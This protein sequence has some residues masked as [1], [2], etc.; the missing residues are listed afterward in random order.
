[1]ELGKHEERVIWFDRIL[2]GEGELCLWYESFWASHTLA[3]PGNWNGD[4][5]I[6]FTTWCCIS[7]MLRVPLSHL[8]RSQ[9][10]F[11]SLA[12][13]F[14]AAASPSFLWRTDWWWWDLESGGKVAQFAF[15][16]GGLLWLLSQ[17][18][19]FTIWHGWIASISIFHPMFFGFGSIAKV[20]ATSITLYFIVHVLHIC[21]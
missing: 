18:K 9:S 4:W 21:L 1:M 19:A 6:V 7:V 17:S 8:W 20:L 11:S 2:T 12:G 5:I 3:Y 15:G 13:G 10:I 14:V 16:F